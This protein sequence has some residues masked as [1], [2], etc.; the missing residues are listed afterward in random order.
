MKTLS[1]FL[2]LFLGAAVAFGQTRPSISPIEGVTEV[3]PLYAFGPR[4]HPLLR[5][6]KQHEGVDFAVPLGTR[7]RAAASGVVLQAEKF[8]GYGLTVRLKHADGYETLYAH[9]QKILVKKGQTVTQGQIIARSGNSGTS[10]APHLHYEV[11]RRG[12]RVDPEKFLAS[13]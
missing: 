1:C 3:A 8:A 2:F 4:L 11:I 12:E 10:S 7:V 9:L 13:K 5:I 6:V